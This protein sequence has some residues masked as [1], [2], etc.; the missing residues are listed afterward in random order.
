M[1]QAGVKDL[2]E[3]NRTSV[4]LAVENTWVASWTFRDSLREN[5][6]ET[7]T[8]LQKQGIQILML[9]GDKKEVADEIGQELGIKDIYAELLPSDKASIIRN[10]QSQG[11]K[12]AFV[13]DGIN[14]A[15]SL[16]IADVGMALASGT[17]IAIETAG[18][19]LMR[20]DIA[21]I[22]TAASIA[23]ATVKTI[24]FNLLWAFGYNIILIPL[25]A[26]VLYPLNGMMLH[27][28][29]AGA[30][31]AFSSVSVVLNSLRLKYTRLP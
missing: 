25:A 4:F 21:T 3:T 11:H 12:V 8:Q 2:P 18:A 9:T 14:D 7:L 28:M 10:Y 20:S 29:I 27:P 31:M 23:R 15:E 13:G 1:E 19:T 26:G 6:K 16:A 17:D 30:A 5:A 22:L 24:R